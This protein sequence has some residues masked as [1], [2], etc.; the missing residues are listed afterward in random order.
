[1]TKLLKRVSNS[2]VTYFN[3][4]YKRI[5]PLFQ[6]IYKAVNIDNEHYLL[7]VSRYIHLNPMKRDNGNAFGGPSLSRDGPQKEW[8]SYPD[9]LGTRKTD[10]LKP[11]VVLSYFNKIGR[12]SLNQKKINTYK[13][14]VEDYAAPPEEIIG[15]LALE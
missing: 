3:K 12:K 5:G 6:G 11:E 9:Y 4:K 1:M 10:W 13:N 8:S 7:H 15:P 2:Y 14:F